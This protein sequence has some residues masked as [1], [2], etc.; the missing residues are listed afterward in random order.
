[1]AHW[2]PSSTLGSEWV[3]AWWVRWKFPGEDSG[4]R[5]QMSNGADVTNFFVWQTV[6]GPVASDK[7]SDSTNYTWKH[8][9]STD[10][11]SGSWSVHPFAAK[12]G[13]L[14]KYTQSTFEYLS[15]VCPE[16]VPS[17]VDYVHHLQDKPK[18][19]PLSDPDVAFTDAKLVALPGDI[20]PKPPFVVFCIRCYRCGVSWM[21]RAVTRLPE[22]EEGYCPMCGP[23]DNAMPWK[24]LAETLEPYSL[25]VDSK[26]RDASGEIPVL[27][28]PEFRLEEVRPYRSTS[29]IEHGCTVCKCAEG[30]RMDCPN[31]PVWHEGTGLK[32]AGQLTPEAKKPS[33]DWQTIK[34]LVLPYQ[35]DKMWL[36]RPPCQCPMGDDLGLPAYMHLD[37]CPAQY[38]ESGIRN[39]GN[40]WKPFSM[41]LNK[42][43][44]GVSAPGAPPLPELRQPIEPQVNTGVDLEDLLCA[45]VD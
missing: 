34:K 23:T 26:Y 10:R 35:E 42:G 31:R 12:G 21:Y 6:D 24:S 20:I 39:S 36:E 8:F 29:D 2:N 4:E 11:R 38:T 28:E 44:V 41:L 17:F 18:E 40:T 22:H 25:V 15:R 32:T 37:R 14:F 33:R 3:Q 9:P 27:Q 13:V 1:M 30:H 5:V 7:P 16:S 43:L 45:N 19:K